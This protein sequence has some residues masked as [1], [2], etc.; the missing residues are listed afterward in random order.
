MINISRHEIFGL[1]PNSDFH[2]CF[3]HEVQ[4]RLRSQEITDKDRKMEIHPV[5]GSRNKG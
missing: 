3:P 4:T 1:H 5:N 2:R